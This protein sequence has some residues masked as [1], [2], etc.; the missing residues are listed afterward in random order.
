MDRDSKEEASAQA[1]RVIPKLSSQGLLMGL[2]RL[3]HADG[4]DQGRRSIYDENR[5]IRMTAMRDELL[6]RLANEKDETKR[7]W[8]HN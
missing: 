2:M 5:W 7:K 1:K 4:L 6:T 8:L 3:A